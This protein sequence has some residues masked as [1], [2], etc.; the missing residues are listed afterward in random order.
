MHKITSID[1]FIK[2]LLDLFNDEFSYFFDD[3]DA[4]YYFMGCGCYEL[5]Q[6]IKNY[7][8]DAE[9]VVNKDFDHCAIL[10]E[11]KIFDALSAVSLERALKKGFSKDFYEKRLDDYF[12]YQKEEIDNFEI[13]F[14]SGKIEG[15]PLVYSLINEIDNI[16]T[17]SI[18]H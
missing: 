11:G 12:I 17:I 4:M 6:I 18:E 14:R 10:Y 3:V 8:P 2:F 15:K 7:F 9:F 1:E 5:A 16:D 13:P